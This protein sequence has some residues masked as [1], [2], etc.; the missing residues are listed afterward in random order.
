MPI[1]ACAILSLV[2]STPLM[3]CIFNCSTPSLLQVQ[4]LFLTASYFSQL[5]ASKLERFIFTGELILPKSTLSRCFPA[6]TKQYGHNHILL[7]HL[8]L[9]H[10][11]LSHECLLLLILIPITF[12]SQSHAFICLY[13]KPLRFWRVT[14][15]I[16][17]YSSNIVRL[18][19]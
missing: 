1:Q 8:Y 15:K 16:H 18:I 4:N 6:T 11:V 14:T 9:K 5:G 7:I 17:K 3:V 10:Q 12:L 2:S 19:F 13:A